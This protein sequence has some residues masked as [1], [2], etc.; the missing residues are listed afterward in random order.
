MKNSNKLLII[1]TKECNRKC[2]FCIDR[3]NRNYYKHSKKFI[4]LDTVKNILEFAKEKNIKTVALNGGEPT[5]HPDVVEIAK[6]VKSY[7]FELKIFTNY[8][9]PE[10][11]KKLDGIVD[12]IRVSYYGPM[13]LPKQSDFKSKLTV[14]IMLK[15]DT[16]PTI[17]DLISFINKYRDDFTNIKIHTLMQNNDYSIKSQVDFLEY[18]N[19][20]YPLK[21]NEKGDYYHEFMGLEIER[22]DLGN[23]NYET[24]QRLYKAHMDGT[25]S[26]YFEE[27]HYKIGYLN[28]NDKLTKILRAHRN[29][30]YRTN[31]INAYQKGYLDYDNFDKYLPNNNF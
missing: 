2:K 24:Q 7:G 16:F 18:L 13:K 22:E 30:I 1:L 8:D 6:L 10:V 4:D 9:Y 14:K 27:D 29:S 5:L 11:I 20:H 26:F 21:R 25:I 15:K 28:Q 31:V 12:I 17:D 19:E 23:V 3:P